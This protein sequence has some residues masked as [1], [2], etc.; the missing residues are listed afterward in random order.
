MAAVGQHP[1]HVPHPQQSFFRTIWETE[2]L[3]FFTFF[4]FFFALIAICVHNKDI[5]L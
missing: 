3:L 4:R 2:L 1:A 5:I